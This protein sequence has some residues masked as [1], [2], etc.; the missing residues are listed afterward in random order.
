MMRKSWNFTLVFFKMML[1][2]KLPYLWTL[3]A[4]VLF[5]I[6]NKWEWK[7][8]PP[9]DADVLRQMGFYWSYIII[10]VLVNGLSISLVYQKDSGFLKT[11]QFL[12]G[13]K[14]PIVLGLAMTYT[15]QAW[16]CL[17]V[18]TTASSVVFGLAWPQ[19]ILLASL[20][21]LAV[22]IPIGFLVITIPVLVKKSASAAVLM[23]IV[24]IAL[25][26]ISGE[27][28]SELGFWAVLLRDLNPFAFTAGWS[29]LLSQW[30]GYDTGA[31][32]ARLLPLLIVFVVY[33]VIGRG[34]WRRFRSLSTT[35]RT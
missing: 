28:G 3:L 23:N 30:V 21:L 35:T 29:S 20:T 31:S 7:E 26:Y 16:F 22:V 25:I 33:L 32:A 18:F 34:F 24:I 4:P 1:H 8:Q 13:S 14:L 19:L 12:A 9:G 17:I 11:Y 5:F 2:E 27:R 10:T 15:L 6:Y